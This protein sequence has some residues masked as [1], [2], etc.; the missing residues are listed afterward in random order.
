MA[1]VFANG[2]DCFG[3]C[4]ELTFQVVSINGGFIF[5][6]LL[7]FR[8]RCVLFCYV[9]A[10]VVILFGMIRFTFSLGSFTFVLSHSSGTLI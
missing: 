3:Y 5:V 2:G 1:H 10:A 6:L 8:F 9:C 4:R 7:L